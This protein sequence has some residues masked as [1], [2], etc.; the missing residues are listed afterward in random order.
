M[1][2]IKLILDRPKKDATCAL[3]FHIIH[4]RKHRIVRSGINIK[5]AQWN[6]SIIINTPKQAQLNNIL[7]KQKSRVDDILMACIL[8]P[9][10][11]NT[12]TDSIKKAL[13]QN[14]QQV[15][16]A[17]F[18]E[19]MYYDFITTNRDGNASAYQT[20]IKE[21]IKF[22]GGDVL[23]NKEKV[24]INKREVD[25]FFKFSGGDIYF[26]ELDYIKLN[27]FKLHHLAAGHK[28]NTIGAYL[29]CIRAIYNE[30]IKHGIIKKEL[31]PFVKGLIP[32]AQKT[33]KKQYPSQ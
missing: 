6:G 31:Y 29:R 2:S 14:T 12:L 33:K 16:L 11:I 15:T 5:P 10:S 23:T 1:P 21:F 20:A 32:S 7:L 3:V 9:V 25:S 8:H 28:P 22:N 4:D 27:A 26:S 30:A 18:T 13:N 19:K 17:S 24:N